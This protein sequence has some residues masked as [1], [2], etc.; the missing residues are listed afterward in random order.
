MSRIRQ[1]LIVIALTFFMSV[2]APFVTVGAATTDWPLLADF[3]GALDTKCRAQGYGYWDRNDHE[4]CTGT[5][6]NDAM[7]A[8]VA[9]CETGGNWNHSQPSYT[10]GL[11]FYRS[12]WTAYK[13]S[14]MPAAAQNAAP[15]WQREVAERIN[16]RQGCWGPVRAQYGH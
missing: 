11:G 12:T 15:E 2:T 16:F 10:G 1:G 13:D 14:W 3:V 4:G 7:W 5:T 9:K 8:A 6:S